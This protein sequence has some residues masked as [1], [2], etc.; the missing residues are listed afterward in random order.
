VQWDVAFGSRN[1]LTWCASNCPLGPQKVPVPV[2]GDLKE[3]YA[4]I[5]VK[6]GD[7]ITL[8]AVP[9]TNYI[10]HTPLVCQ[11]DEQVLD[12]CNGTSDIAQLNKLGEKY[13]I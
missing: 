13:I 4:L 9:Y 11:Y 3:P 2:V 6:S 7:S 1:N 8:R 10:Y 5:S 12:D